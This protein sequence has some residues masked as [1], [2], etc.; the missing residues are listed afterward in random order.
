VC[1]RFLVLEPLRFWQKLRT[2]TTFLWFLIYICQISPSGFQYMGENSNHLSFS[3]NPLYKITWGLCPFSFARH[4]CMISSCAASKLSLSCVAEDSINGGWSQ[5]IFRLCEKNI[6]YWKYCAQFLYLSDM[7]IVGAFSCVLH[8]NGKK[9]VL[10]FKPHC[11]N[12][13]WYR[14]LTGCLKRDLNMDE[15]VLCYKVISSEYVS[16]YAWQ[17]IWLYRI[18]IRI[19]KYVV[20]SLVYKAA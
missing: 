15:V 9:N 18:C 6:F 19:D 8:V 2:F 11:L 20:R 16:V 10:P 1:L 5:K 13:K 7:S 3:R 12:G 14:I 4:V 17:I